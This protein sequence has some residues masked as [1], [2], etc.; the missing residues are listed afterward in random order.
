L[1]LSGP[2]YFRQ[3]H[4]AIIG[5]GWRDFGHLPVSESGHYYQDLN[6]SE[7]RLQIRSRHTEGLSFDPTQYPHRHKKKKSTKQP[8]QK[9]TKP[10]YTSPNYE[11]D[12]Y[13]ESDPN[14]GSPN[15]DFYSQKGQ[16]LMN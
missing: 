9:S 11:E 15:L 2:Y 4:F 6:H 13:W 8:K 7:T 3:K 1:E 5:H 12:I 16:M 10:R 14:T